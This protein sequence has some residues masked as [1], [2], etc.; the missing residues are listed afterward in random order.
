MRSFLLQ[1]SVIKPEIHFFFPQTITFYKAVIVP[2]PSWNATCTNVDITACSP[3]S[4]VFCVWGWES[5]I[6]LTLC[7]WGS[8]VQSSSR[9]IKR[10][11]II[12]Y[13][14]QYFIQSSEHKAFCWSINGFVCCNCFSLATLEE[15]ETSCIVS[16]TCYWLPPDTEA[17]AS[18]TKIKVVQQSRL[19]SDDDI[20][21]SE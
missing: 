13:S 6:Q 20:F 18:F 3:W 1:L 7:F 4:Q 11:Q 10:K 19:V 16:H 2:H 12:S 17:K 5:T 9:E 14:S 21:R 15:A 8:E